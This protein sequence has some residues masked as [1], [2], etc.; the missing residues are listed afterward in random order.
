MTLEI[1]NL[2][3]QID[4]K[5]AL[6]NLSF[7]VS[8]GEVFGLLGSDKSAKTLILRIVSGLEKA[9]SGSIYLDDQEIANGR[10]AGFY[11]LADEA[12]SRWRQLFGSDQTV[13]RAIAQIKLL[14]ESLGKLENVFL[15]ENPVQNLDPNQ[16]Q[17]FAKE[18]RRL[19]KAKRLCTLIATNDPL[20]VFQ[21]CDRVAVLDGG[22]IIQIGGVSDVYSN[23]KTLAAAELFGSINLIPAKRTTSSKEENPE[24]VTI[25]GEQRISLD[26]LEKAEL[27][28][29]NQP[30]TLAIRPENVSIS[31]GASFPEDNLIRATVVGVDFLGSTTLIKLDANGL[32]LMAL[33]L[34]VVGLSVGDECML[35]IPPDRIRILK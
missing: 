18:I 20:E 10:E 23:P 16:T 26:K 22:E 27:G 19:T 14:E 33:V 2:S 3:K 11:L 35:G 8:K 12:T 4:G 34:R 6:N 17:R 7:S 29:I 25:D 9:N 32:K 1:K 21:L 30:V 24:F 31:F 15:V 13:S 28:A 5:L